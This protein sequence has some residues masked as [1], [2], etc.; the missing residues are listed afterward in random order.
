MRTLRSVQSLPV[1]YAVFVVFATLFASIPAQATSPGQNGRIVFPASPSGFFQ[2]Y[3][4]NPDGT[5]LVQITNLAETAF[6]AWSPHFSSDG[7][8]IVFAYGPMDTNGTAHPDVYAVHP[9][10]TDLRRLTFDGLSGSPN[11]SPDGKTIV[12]ARISP[13]TGVNV[14]TTMGADGTGKRSLTSDFWDSLPAAY[15]PD[16]SR[17]VFYSQ[18]GGLA[19]AIWI[20]NRDGSDQTRLTP[21][22]VEGAPTDVSPDGQRILF[23]NH[24]NSDLAQAIW[25]MNI[26]GTDLKQLTHPK[27]RVLVADILGAY[28]PDATKIVFISNRFNLNRAD[29]FTI[30]ADGSHLKRIAIGVGFGPSWGAKP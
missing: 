15:T 28:S 21:P 16:G 2:L 13:R 4:I 6:F 20:M 30:N 11:R 29:L 19:S 22:P 17:I 7:K 1:G 24:N 12:F 8:R 5:D 14:V 26:D 27:G 10:G 9:D 23:F 3:T 18:R 25:V